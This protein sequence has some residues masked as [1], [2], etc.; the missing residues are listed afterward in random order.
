[1]S[2]RVP[3][4]DHSPSQPP[5]SPGTAETAACLPRG[6][7]DAV[8]FHPDRTHILAA[9]VMMLIALVGV[10]Y[11]P[12]VLG[13]VLLIPLAFIFYVLKSA[14]R[15]DDT[16]ITVVR[17][18]SSNVS[19]PWEKI[20]G[21]EFSGAKALLRTTGDTSVRMP[22]VTFNSLPR[23]EAASQGRIPDPI[24]QGRAAAAE[25]V[26]VIRRDGYSELREKPRVDQ[27]PTS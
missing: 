8:E 12:L 10:A 17:A 13:W 4:P 18:Y 23:L 1:M 11:S 16:G 21:V 2:S 26:E 6:Q 7:Q 27:D 19:V 5:R 3:S 20:R 25:K 24:T 9:V 22:G 14:T 15:V